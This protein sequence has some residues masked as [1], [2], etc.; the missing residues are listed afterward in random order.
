M[1][2]E[3]LINGTIYKS[4]KIHEEEL[5]NENVFYNVVVITAECYKHRYLGYLDYNTQH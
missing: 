4:K 3:R 5:L 1:P 2:S